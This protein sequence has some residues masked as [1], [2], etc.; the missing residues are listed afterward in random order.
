[1]KNMILKFA[2]TV[3]LTS[4][5]ATYLNYQLGLTLKGAGFNTKEI[6]IAT[7]NVLYQQLQHLNLKN[8]ESQPLNEGKKIAKN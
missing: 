7:K 1:M 6:R 2:T 8:N 5:H 3:K 4:N